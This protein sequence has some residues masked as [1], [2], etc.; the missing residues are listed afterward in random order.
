MLD[1]AFAALFA[2]VWPLY[3]MVVEWP[4]YLRHL[5]EG[6]PGVRL[7]LY[8]KTLIQQWA[9]A[10]GTVLLW[11]RGRRAW[12]ALG[13]RSLEGWRLG[14]AIV[15]VAAIAVMVV[16]QVRAVASRPAVRERLRGRLGPLDPILPHTR[17]EF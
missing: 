5:A 8:A 3:T 14:V 4:R 12:D 7:K 6:R 16:R 11:V 10:A 2:V 9:L 17:T 1:L 15:L 13:L